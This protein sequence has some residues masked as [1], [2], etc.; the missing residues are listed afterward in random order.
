[1]NTHYL[2]SRCYER[3]TD[4]YISQNERESICL[5]CYEKEKGNNDKNWRELEDKNNV[6]RSLIHSKLELLEDELI[7]GIIDEDYDSLK[8]A[9]E[10]RAKV[11]KVI[12]EEI[13]VLRD[14]KFLEILSEIRGRLDQ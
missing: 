14:E 11:L 4:L 3:C 12:K 6:E 9:A 2:C 7:N 5:K 1:M 10:K 13:E 8:E